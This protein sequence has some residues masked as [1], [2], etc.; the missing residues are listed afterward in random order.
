MKIKGSKKRA[1]GQS[2]VSDQSSILMTLTGARNCT[3]LSP[4]PGG[5]GLVSKN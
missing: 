3:I 1:K 4:R 5:P 2:A